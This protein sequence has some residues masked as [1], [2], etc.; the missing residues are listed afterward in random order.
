MRRL[1]GVLVLLGAL[2]LA[3]PV[4]SAAAQS[5]SGVGD[6]GSWWYGPFAFPGHLGGPY[7]SIG[8]TGFGATGFG[9]GQGAYGFSNYGNG[10]MLGV[11]PL[12]PTCG[13][14]GNYPYLYPY[15]TGYP[16][17]NA[18]GPLGGFALSSM[19]NPNPFLQSVSCNG[20]LLGSSFPTQSSLL[21]PGAAGQFGISA[22]QNVLNLA[23]PAFPTLSQ[24]GTF[25]Q[26]NLFGCAQLR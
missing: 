7:G 17:S 21:F 19:G 14:F 1:I 25:T 8:A 12:L 18:A 11:G 9:C 16:Y 15:Y 24:F 13:G 23:N 3:I 2:S 10:T 20:L 5:S 22:N 26:S 6:W 4:S